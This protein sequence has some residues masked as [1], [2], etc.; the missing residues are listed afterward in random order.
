M[1]VIDISAL[2]AMCARVV[3]NLAV[4]LKSPSNGGLS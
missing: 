2:V 3:P 1:S 4:T